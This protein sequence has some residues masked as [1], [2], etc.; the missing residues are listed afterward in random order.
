[1]KPPL[2]TFVKWRVVHAY[3]NEME[4]E[5]TDEELLN[6]MREQFDEICRGDLEYLEVSML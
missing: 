1:M 5:I 2:Q 4:D 3:K 6:F